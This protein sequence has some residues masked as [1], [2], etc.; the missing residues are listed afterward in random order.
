MLALTSRGFKILQ[1]LTALAVALGFLADVAKAEK[2]LTIASPSGEKVITLDEDPEVAISYT[3]SGIKLTFV[4]L[5]VKT[6]CIE[7]PS[8]SGVCRLQAYDGGITPG[9]GGG[10]GASTPKDLDAPSLVAGDQQVT[11]SWNAPADDG[12][13]DIT[14]YR[15]Q[16]ASG[17]T[18]N[19][20]T[21]VADTGTAT[22]G[23]IAT[24]LQNGESYRF[25]VA[26]MNG[27]GLGPFSPASA[28]AIPTGDTG[29]GSFAT[30]CN[31]VPSNV[32]CEFFNG[33]SLESEALAYFDIKSGKILSIPFDVPTGSN[34]KGSIK[35]FNFTKA[36]G[37]LFTA[38][39]SYEAG[40]E[41]TNPN[42]REDVCE[43]SAVIAESLIPWTNNANDTFRCN[44][45]EKPVVFANFKW[46]VVRNG[47]LAGFPGLKLEL[48]TR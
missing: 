37:Y 45:S 41:P 38:W 16:I 25:R 2:T 28:A 33:G 6:V 26:A 32:Q 39:Y 18:L 47:A 5:S 29:G 22:R 40:G 21:L 7:D 48:Q 4:N 34:V 36:D 20:A 23:Y 46:E 44:I 14:G 13:D 35:Y 8:T 43:A 27:V 1:V 17:G 11:L 10:G 3:P 24:G 12:G 9:G 30:A 19:W 31:S 15:I 42:A